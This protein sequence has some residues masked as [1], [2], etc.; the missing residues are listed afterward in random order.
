M[1]LLVLGADSTI[2]LTED[3]PKPP[4]Q[5]AILSHTWVGGQEV[6]LEDIARGEGRQKTGYQKLLF[7]GQQAAHDDLPYFW[8]DTCCIDKSSSAELAEALNSMFDWYQSASKC[9][10]YLADV[11]KGSDEERLRSSWKHSFR[12]SRWFTR[13]WTLQELLAPSIVDFFSS[14]GQWLGDKQSLG[15]LVHEITK[16]PLSA[17]RGAALTQFSIDERISW[18]DGRNTT[19]EEDMAYSL[20]GICGVYLLPIYSE[21][22]TNALRRLRHEVSKAKVPLVLEKLPIAL[23]AAFDSHAEEHNA[24]CLQGT[25]VGILRDIEEWAHD[26]NSETVFWLNGMAGTGKSTIARTLA[27]TASS[28]GQLGGSFFFKRGEG[29]RGGVSKFFST[30]AAQ[31][32]SRL[33]AAAT[34][35]QQAIDADVALFGKAMRE[36]FQKLM[37]EPLTKMS[38]EGC[39]TSHLLIIVD[40]LDECEHEDDAKRII[41]LLS[42]LK[43][44]QRPRLKVFLTS[45]PELPIRLGFADIKGSYQ[46]FI[47]HEV[48]ELVIKRDIDS[49]LRNELTRARNS[50]NLS[51][52]EDRHVPASWPTEADIQTLVE[53]SAP[54]F[55]FAATVCRFVADRR[56]GDPEEQLQNVLSYHAAAPSSELGVTYMPVL[57]KLVPVPSSKHK[58]QALERFRLVVGSIILLGAPLSRISLARLLNTS[59]KTVA[60]VLDLLHSV[61]SVPDS[62]YEP[63]RLLHLSFRELLLDPESQENN[64]FWIDE[65]RAH[66]QLAANCLRIMN[67]SLLL[68]ICGCPVQTNVFLDVYRRL[69]PEIMEK[70]EI[71]AFCYW[72]HHLE[73][74]NLSLSDGDEIH[75]FLTCHFLRWLEVMCVLEGAPRSLEILTILKGITANR[76]GK[77]YAFLDDAIS[78]VVANESSFQTNPLQVYLSGL[79]FS[80]KDGIIRTTFQRNV[81]QWISI[82]S[83]MENEITEKQSGRIDTV[84]YSPDGQFLLSVSGN[85][86][87]RWDAHTGRLQQ[88]FTGHTDAITSATISPGGRTVAS[89]SL[90][91]TV[92]L[93]DAETD[94]AQHT[95][96]HSSPVHA[97]T[98]SPDS[99]L[100]ASGS[101]DGTVM[102]WDTNTSEERH[103]F[104]ENGALSI[105]FSPDGTLIAAGSDNGHILV[106]T[107]ESTDQGRILAGRGKAVVSVA[108]SPDNQLIASASPGENINI[109][110]LDTGACK[111]TNH[112]GTAAE[113]L[114]FSPDGSSLVTA[115][116]V[117]PIR[118]VRSYR[119]SLVTDDDDGLDRPPQ[120]PQLHRGTW[121]WGYGISEDR[122][123]I[124][125]CGDRILWLP[126]SFRPT[127]GGFAAYESSVAI[128]CESGK[129]F[130]F[131]F[132]MG[133]L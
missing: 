28:A 10:V 14:D 114:S 104:L 127:A 9:Y 64:M 58:T 20:L 30:L 113:T 54:L 40:A 22:K 17:L 48:P 98:L 120:L 32:V 6:T 116:G 108:I 125:W 115:A 92:K 7:C 18:S 81:P 34:S 49:L 11:H 41:H 88:T 16:I 117:V 36:Q 100:V 119:A 101:G 61:L 63:I 45:R 65:R 57:H 91:R 47:L 42:T 31:L 21:G 60:N 129:V 74:S 52:P 26:T 71:Y 55:I 130:V 72:A 97:V 77:L 93:W 82:H 25:R 23:D 19:R 37:L 4:P 118:S 50:Y 103:I 35:V 128:G 102:L 84:N 89:A 46:D 69:T 106:C 43:R 70:E 44:E 126:P 85:T 8:V 73:L 39:M 133:G 90:D 95:L 86:V 1:R 2:S 13:G 66:R 94:T 12:S 105:A 124:T 68:G 131:Q 38:T 53:L 33:P 87:K 107:V 3:F 78:F 76:E 121:C 80:P 67:D 79:L 123:W 122:S 99:Q 96:L 75:K 29:D 132:D 111:Q 109:W 83:A 110:D 59:M 56:L 15:Q 112:A 5:Y 62:P 24:T 27:H 51:V